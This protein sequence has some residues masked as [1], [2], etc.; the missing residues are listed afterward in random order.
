MGR[1]DNN[2]LHIHGKPLPIRRI[3]SAIRDM[4][5]DAEDILWKDLM[6]VSRKEDRFNINLETIQDNLLF[7]SAWSTGE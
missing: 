7:A 1:P 6:L 5:R 3:K 4:I 2:T